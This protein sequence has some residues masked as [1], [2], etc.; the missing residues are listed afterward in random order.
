MEGTV[1]DRADELTGVTEDSVGDEIVENEI[2]NSGS[3]GPTSEGP[4]S[5]SVSGKEG[6]GRP[7]VEGEGT[8]AICGEERPLISLGLYVDSGK[9]I[10]SGRISSMYSK[11]SDSPVTVEGMVGIGEGTLTTASS[12]TTEIS[13]SVARETSFSQTH[14]A[15][16]NSLDTSVEHTSAVTYSVP[17]SVGQMSAVSNSVN[18]WSVT[19]FSTVS[20]SVDRVSAVS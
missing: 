13:S 20:Y 18:E 12:S 17:G 5:E 6:L 15:V 19:H 10:F 8:G 11:G 1:S 4:G 7:G 3:G 2:D 14:P 9:G 16:M